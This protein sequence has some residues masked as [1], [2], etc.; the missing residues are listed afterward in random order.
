MVVRWSAIVKSSMKGKWTVSA[1]L[2]AHRVRRCHL[3][4][5]VIGILIP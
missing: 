3:N 1:E 4:R 2:G 5:R